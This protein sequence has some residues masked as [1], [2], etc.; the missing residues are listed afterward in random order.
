[1]IFF[2]QILENRECIKVVKGGCVCYREQR[3]SE[4][5]VFGGANPYFYYKSSLKLKLL[6]IKL[7]NPLYLAVPS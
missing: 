2:D 5:L 1:M 6:K 7:K 3:R 4:K